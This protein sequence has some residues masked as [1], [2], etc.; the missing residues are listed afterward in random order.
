MKEFKRFYLWGMNMKFF[1]GLYFTAM[2]FLAGILTLCYGGDS[3]TLMTLLQMFAVSLVIAVLQV[4]LLPDSTSYF[5]GILMKRSVALLVVSAVLTGLCAHFGG[6]FAGLPV[7]CPWLM[8]AFMVFGIVC[9]LIGLRFE[10]EAD[11]VRLNDDLKAYQE[12]R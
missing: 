8:A 12:K 4:T 6:W 11:T 10:Q 7:W 1:M 3:L 2:I 5:K 9:M